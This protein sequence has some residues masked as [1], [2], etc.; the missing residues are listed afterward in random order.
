MNP[1][2]P[3]SRTSNR[4]NRWR[5]SSSQESS[6]PSSVPRNALPA[7]A[8][9]SASGRCSKVSRR[10]RT[11]ASS[12]TRKVSVCRRAR[13]ASVDSRSRATMRAILRANSPRRRGM[14]PGVKGTGIPSRC[15]RV[16]GRKQ[17]SDGQGVGEV[18]DQ[19]APQDGYYPD[20]QNRQH[21]GSRM[22]HRPGGG[23]G[24]ALPA[25]NRGLAARGETPAAFER[26]Y[27]GFPHGLPADSGVTRGCGQPLPARSLRRRSR[28]G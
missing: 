2:E 20:Q 1:R 10:C 25:R 27:A 23:S 19:G 6:P 14:M 9:S 3:T 28:R 24:P 17:H 7:C 8:A 11:W 13:T 15:F 18:T 5:T 26:R 12:A 4:C 21:G 16:S 22:G